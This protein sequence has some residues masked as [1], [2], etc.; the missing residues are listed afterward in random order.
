MKLFILSLKMFGEDKWKSLLLA[1]QIFLF[2]YTLNI[3]LGT[4]QYLNSLNNFAEKAEINNAAYFSYN[5]IMG[6][7]IVEKRDME[8]V[9]QISS[10][11]KDD[12]GNFKEEFLISTCTALD[13]E[14]GIR[15]PMD[16]YEG[17]FGDKIQYKLSDGAWFNND[18]INHVVIS[19]DLSKFYKVG[20]HVPVTVYDYTSKRYEITLEIVGVIDS[21]YVFNFNR[22]GNSLGLDSIVV[23]Y[24]SLMIAGKLTD[25]NGDVI[26]GNPS[27]GRLIFTNTKETNNQI[28]SDWQDKLKLYG[29]LSA[30]EYMKE[31]TNEL[32]KSKLF[33]QFAIEFIVLLLAVSGIGANNFLTMLMKRKEFSIY[34]LCGLRWKN[35]LMLST[36]K[37]L[38]TILIPS[39][40]AFIVIKFQAASDDYF[41]SV[42]DMGN[43]AICLV[44]IFII[45]LLTAIPMYIKMRNES[46]VEMFRKE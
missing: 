25:K 17:D 21:D 6:R 18:A 4:I 42:I 11:V 39:L 8:L 35:C 40:L 12:L 38:F 30:I 26:Y 14:T 45:Y 46:P 34:F 31:T 44:V 43:F 27:L 24:E 3:S 22:S 1:L 5:S 33:E 23:P 20:E 29:N 36:F 7:E 28:F 41:N 2:I 13:P 10:I 16:I 9:Q 19:K 32:N 37:N 15:F